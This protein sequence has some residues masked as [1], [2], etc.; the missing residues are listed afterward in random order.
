VVV[1]AP[2]AVAVAA[3]VD[4]EGRFLW[5]GLPEVETELE[6]I[7]MGRQRNGC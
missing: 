1:V 4:E 2:A 3:V 7:A 6:D 5:L